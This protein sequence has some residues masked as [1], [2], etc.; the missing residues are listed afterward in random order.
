MES[1]A[2]SRGWRLAAGLV[3]ATAFAAENPG[4]TFHRDVEPLLQKHCQGC[5]RPG[6]I[7]PMPLLTCAQVRP[8]SKSI[9]EAVL[10][11]KMPLLSRRPDSR[12]RLEPR[13]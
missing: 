3:A 9:R 13:T 5:H 2:L 1:P 7:G 4:I 12:R 6:E 11:K 10:A 8:W